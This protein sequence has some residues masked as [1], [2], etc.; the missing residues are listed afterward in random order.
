MPLIGDPGVIDP[1]YFT[2]FYIPE[3]KNSFLNL[4]AY[5]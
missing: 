4:S 5:I 1:Q 3:K 2:K